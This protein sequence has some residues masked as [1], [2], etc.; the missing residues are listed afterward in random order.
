MDIQGGVV[1]AYTMYPKFYVGKGIDEYI[2]QLGNL[3]YQSEDMCKRA[4]YPAAGLVADRVRFNIDSIE[5]RAPHGNDGV[6]EDQRRGLKEGFG[7]SQFQNRFGYIHVKL[8]FDGYN[9]HITDTYPTGQP[10]AMIA[11]AINSGTS[12][13]K[14]YPFVDWA[15]RD[16]R[17]DAEKLMKEHIEYTIYAIMKDE[18]A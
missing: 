12:F 2:A 14:K 7:I 8:G 15:V 11:R 9:Q 5:T 16:T 13:A 10:N 4:I 3:M 6:F 18:R 17:E 1:M